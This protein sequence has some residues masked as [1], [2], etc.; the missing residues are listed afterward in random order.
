MRCRGCRCSWRAACRRFKYLTPKATQL[1]ID[2][3]EKPL[4]SRVREKAAGPASP[5]HKRIQG[6][7]RIF[8]ANLR[9]MADRVCWKRRFL[10]GRAA[11]AQSCKTFAYIPIQFIPFLGSSKLRKGNQGR[12][13][14]RLPDVIVWWDDRGSPGGPGAGDPDSAALVRGIAE[15]IG[16][17]GFH[18]AAFA[19]RCPRHCRRP[20][21]HPP[22]AS[23]P[24]GLAA[25]PRSRR[26]AA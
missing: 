15:G 9:R 24:H 11:D 26:C 2:R 19:G 16:H 12:V 7:M 21:A 17:P 14:V 6:S 3:F 1:Q 8:I 23:G 22:R 13:V 5:P 10:T 4:L 18:C 25:P 20:A